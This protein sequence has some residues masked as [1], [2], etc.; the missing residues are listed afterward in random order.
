MGGI[1][2]YWLWK[3]RPKRKEKKKKKKQGGGKRSDL[4]CPKCLKTFFVFKYRLGKVKFC[5]HSC[6]AGFYF[7]GSKNP[8]WN[9][10]K[11][12]W[13]AKVNGSKKYKDWRISVFQR[14]WFTCKWCGH[15]S[16]KSKAHG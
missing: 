6:R 4:N 8:N 16:K 13:R 12:G 11:S 3:K 14:D 7:T 10:G 2:R 5:S 15:R 1:N 9:G